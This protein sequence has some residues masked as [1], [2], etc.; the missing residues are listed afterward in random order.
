MEDR[1]L[2]N[3]EWFFRIDHHTLLYKSYL[4]CYIYRRAFGI[5]GGR[6]Q[7][8]KIT[9]DLVQWHKIAELWKEFRSSSSSSSWR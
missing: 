3:Y 5:G 8:S 2:Y 6:Y 9:F 4:V 7:A 1:G